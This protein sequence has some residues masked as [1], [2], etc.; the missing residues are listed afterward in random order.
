MRKMSKNAVSSIAKELQDLSMQFRGSQS[1]YLKRMKG[2]EE[3]ERG[4][5]LDGMDGGSSLVEGEI[6]ASNYVDNGFSDEQLNQLTSN[7]RRRL[8]YSQV[9]TA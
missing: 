7:V 1:S 8:F 2:R 6:D 5:G 4:Y 3:R 9:I